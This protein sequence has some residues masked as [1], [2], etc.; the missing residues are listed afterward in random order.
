MD[1]LAIQATFERVV[2]REPTLSEASW[3]QAEL[4]P[5]VV[6]S[7]EAGSPIFGGSLLSFAD[8]VSWLVGQGGSANGYDDDALLQQVG[9]R[10]MVEGEFERILGRTATPAELAAN[11]IVAYGS[12]SGAVAQQLAY[13]AEAANDINA[14]S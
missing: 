3:W 9:L 2:R 12:G 14:F 10:A 4:A 7:D 11:E 1:G 5:Q 8:L 6:G 13:G